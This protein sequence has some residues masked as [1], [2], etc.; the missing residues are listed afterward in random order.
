VNLTLN[1]VVFLFFLSYQNMSFCKHNKLQKIY[2]K[3]NLLKNFILDTIYPRYCVHCQVLLVHDSA[4]RYICQSC[5]PKLSWIDHFCQRCG[6]AVGPEGGLVT[7]C[8]SCLEL[9]PRFVLGRSLWRYQG[10]ASDWIRQLKYHNGRY[11]LPDTMSFIQQKKDLLHFLNHTT[12]IPVPLHSKRLRQRGYNQ[13]EWLAQSIQKITHQTTVYRCLKRVRYTR[14]QV[15]CSKEERLI[16]IKNA[17]E[18]QGNTPLNA[19][20]VYT[21]I[22]DVFTTGA[23]LQA[24]AAVLYKVGA[25]RIQVLTLAHG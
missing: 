5:Y 12:L 25:R 14:S 19:E 1:I 4:Y 23:T 18:F 11:L 10:A 21:L 24:C 17:F 3:L 22:D 9:K 15:Q 6:C 16:N 13:S 20:M 2:K 7:S 8:A